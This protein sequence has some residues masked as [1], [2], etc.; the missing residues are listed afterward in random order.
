MGEITP[1]NININNPLGV[2]TQVELINW[3]QANV[4]WDSFYGD[5][6]YASYLYEAFNLEIPPPF[7]VL[8]DHAV[9]L[10]IAF[11]SDYD[12]QDQQ[13]GHKK[14]K[15]KIKLI[16]MIDDLTKVIEKEKNNQ[17]KTEFKDKVENILTE[18]IGQKIILENVQIIHG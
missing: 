18:K 12:Y 10:T 14:R 13:S 5:N 2:I 17:V 7:A 15:K 11:P 16:F 1:T 4:N 8:W 9:I 6:A 3:E